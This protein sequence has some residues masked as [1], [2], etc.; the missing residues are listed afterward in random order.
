MNEIIQLDDHRPDNRKWFVAMALCLECLHKWVATVP[1]DVRLYSL[2]C[3]KCK[4]KNSFASVLPE[5]FLNASASKDK[6]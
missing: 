6:K 5:E 2:E 4:K 3:P 1:E